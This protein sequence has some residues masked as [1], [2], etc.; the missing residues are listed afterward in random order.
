MITGR[1][2]SKFMEDLGTGYS[3]KKTISKM[4]SEYKLVGNHGSIFL[5]DPLCLS[6]QQWLF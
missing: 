3:P 5:V 2:I 1:L 4:Q 6:E